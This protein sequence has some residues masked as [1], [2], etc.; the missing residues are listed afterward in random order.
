MGEQSRQSSPHDHGTERQAAAARKRREDLR[1][2]R[3]RE[4]LFGPMLDKMSK[5]KVLAL[6]DRVGV[7]FGRWLASK[8]GNKQRWRDLLSANDRVVLLNRIERETNDQA[9]NQ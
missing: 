9:A 5:P 2:Q 3:A 1:R 4:D 6:A 7:P 8:I